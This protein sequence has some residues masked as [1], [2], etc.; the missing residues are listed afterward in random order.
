MSQ[1]SVLHEM[2]SG[3]CTSLQFPI[4]DLWLFTGGVTAFVLCIKL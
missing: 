1:S 4:S 3:E 2:Q